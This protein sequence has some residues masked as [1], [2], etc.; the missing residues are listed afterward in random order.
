MA[1]R[2]FE[3]AR[4]FGVTSTTLM[5]KCRAEGFPAKNHMTTVP[6]DLE[7]TI[8]EWSRDVRLDALERDLA[9]TR[10]NLAELRAALASLGGGA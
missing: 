4:E 1:K 2:I 6:E 5:E 8:R 3:L 10:Q 9:S 7:S